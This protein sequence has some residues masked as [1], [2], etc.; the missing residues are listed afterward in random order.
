VKTGYLQFV[1][2]CQPKNPKEMCQR[3]TDSFIFLLCKTA[4]SPHFAMWRSDLNAA[5]TKGTVKLS[6]YRKMCLMRSWG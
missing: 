3:T 2:M 1:M 5:L 6:R 4:V